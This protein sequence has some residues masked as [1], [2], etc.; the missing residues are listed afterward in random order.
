NDVQVK[1]SLKK[2]LEKKHLLKECIVDIKPYARA[3]TPFSCNAPRNPPAVQAPGPGHAEAV[4]SASFNLHLGSQDRK[5][6]RKSTF[7]VS[8]VI[9]VG[10]I[11]F[12][13]NLCTEMELV[14]TLP[15]LPRTVLYVYGMSLWAHTLFVLSSHTG[16]VTC[17]RWGENGLIYSGSQD[18]TIKVFRGSDGVLCRTLKGHAHWVNSVALNTDYVIRTDPFDPKDSKLYKTRNNMIWVC[19]ELAVL[20]IKCYESATRGRPEIMVSGSD[21]FSR[22]LWSPEK[23]CKCIARMTGLHILINDVKFSPDM[24]FIATASFDKS[25]KLWNGKTGK[26]ISSVHGRAT[27]ISDR[28]VK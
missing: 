3:S 6:N 15:V 27:G 22:M 5:T 21:D 7:S 13:G 19:Q 2:V 18:R 4:I 14:V 16:S 8:V 20:A 12:L 10:L 26:Y 11:L 28:L 9:Q 23:N 24:R 1:D 17:V 25:I